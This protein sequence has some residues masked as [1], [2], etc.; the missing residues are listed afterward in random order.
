M[1]K[2]NLGN[3]TTSLLGFGLM[4]LPHINSVADIDMKTAIEMVD[5]AIASGVDY[6]DTA[7]MYHNG[8]SERFAGEALSRHNRTLYKLANKMPLAFIETAGDVE[9]IFNEQLRK[10]R[11]DYFDYYLLHNINRQSVE[12]MERCHAYEQI[13][14]KKEAGYIGKLGFSFHDT[15]DLLQDTINKHEFD[16]AQI[17]LNY[18]DWEM[19]NASEL[20]AILSTKGI[21]VHVME[22]VR[23]GTLAKPGNEAVQIFGEAAPGVSPASWALRYAASLPGVQVVLSGMSTPEQ[24]A[25]NITTFSPLKPLSDYERTVIDRAVVAWRKTAAIPCT[26]CRYCMDCPAGVE[27]PK[28]LAVYSNYKRNV[29]EKHPLTD[30]L[31]GMEYGFLKSE[32]QASLCTACGE[33]IEKCPQNINI[34]VWMQKIAAKQ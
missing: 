13:L 26:A 4:R 30:M 10:C 29:K 22:P 21:P 31:F 33:C 20:Y 11:V 15:P 32:G 19:Q 5:T 23:G 1:E 12:T 7:W 24:L 8:E 17:Q 34:P 25:N 9:R 18:V 2:R 14:K 27:I 6:F 3:G 16:F 28:N